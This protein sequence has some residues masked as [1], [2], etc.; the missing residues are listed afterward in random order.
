MMTISK[1]DVFKTLIIIWFA[2]TTIYVGWD[3]WSSYAQK[4]IQQAYKTGYA[5]S[6]N[7][8]FKKIDESKCQPIE[9]RKDENTKIQVIDAQCQQQAQ[10]PVT[11]PQGAPVQ[12]K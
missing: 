10:Q 7:D 11:Q 8:L 5:T 1:Q 6:V 3:L 12:K 2:A 9:V 4:G